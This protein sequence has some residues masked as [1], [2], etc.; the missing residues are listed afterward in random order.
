M[1]YDVAHRSVDT[2]LSYR[3]LKR[4]ALSIINASPTISLLEPDKVVTGLAAGIG[5]D[6]SQLVILRVIVGF[7]PVTL[8]IAPTTVWT[9]PADHLKL[10]EL[11]NTAAFIGC[12]TVLVPEGIIQRQPRLDNSRLIENSGAHVTADQRIELMAHLIEHGPT[13]LV[14]LAKS[15]QHDTP[16]AAILNLAA[17]GVLIVES[18]RIIGPY[19]VVHLPDAAT[20]R[21]AG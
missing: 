16:V 1:D 14:D 20:P 6:T 21:L 7:S 5:L 11:K 13:A 10:L 17:S 12:R 18:G 15:I 3:R 19:T 8:V 2:S 9:S 4:N